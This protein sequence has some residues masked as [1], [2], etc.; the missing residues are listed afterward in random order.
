MKFLLPLLILLGLTL[1]MAAQASLPPGVTILCYHHVGPLTVGGDPVNVY[2]VTPDLLRSHFEWL[3]DTGCRVI[4][5][6]EYLRYAK[7]QQALPP[8]S[9]LLTFDDGYQSFETFV[10][11]LLKEFGYTAVLGIVGSWQTKPPA[12]PDR[13]L[14]WDQVRRLESS[15]LVEIASHSF[16]LHSYVPITAFGDPGP[17]ATNLE[18]IGGVRETP[19]AHRAKV[20][21]DLHRSQE[22]M[23]QQL[24]HRVRALVWPYGE[25]N[26]ETIAAAQ[27][28]GFEVLFGLE[29][30]FN[31]P[32]ADSLR[33]AK[34]G[35]VWG[36]P[37]VDELARF[38]GL[39][40]RSDRA[41]RVVQIDLDALYDANRAQFEK[42]IN[43][44]IVRLKKTHA[45]TVFLQAFADENGDGNIEQVYFATSAAPVKADVFAHVTQRLDDAGYRVFAWVP[46]LAGQW[47][48]EGH[49]DD[50]I[51]ASD[52][53]GQGWYRRAT[54]F[55][56]RVRE[57]LKKLFTDLA[58]QAPIQGVLFQDD[59]YMTDYEDDSPAGR[60]AFQARFQQPWSP[61]VL[62]EPSIRREWTKLKSAA[63]NSLTTELMAVVRRYRPDSPSARNIYAEAVTDRRA[64]DWY[65]QDF[66]AYLTLYD[67]TVIMAYPYMEKKG[68]QALRWLE[69]VA[70]AALADRSAAGKVMI[71]LQNFDWNTRRWLPPGELVRQVRTVLAR[72]I[73]HVGYYPED[74]YSTEPFDPPL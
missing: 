66:Q 26:E 15:G 39:G 54:P 51:A 42:N 44:A 9:V 8:R 22:D 67:Y 53:K 11:P 20:R 70:D 4:T 23:V 59:L 32:G 69:S 27:A 46:T 63:I 41:L 64:I 33:A 1:P 52:P 14:N 65:S 24:G 74:L 29:G 49:P 25:Y 10:F 35:I 12:V 71:K 47:L 5:L 43:L 56:P 31:V 48:T 58:S 38:V 34:R 73:L 18:Y 16:D 37:K 45:N 68:D 2:T 21:L 62:S 57:S 30:G 60:A 72:G 61:A 6:D 40:G 55:S 50:R 7:G 17:A 13:V 19:E 3:R 36:A 28:E